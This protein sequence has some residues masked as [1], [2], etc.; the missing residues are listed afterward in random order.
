MGRGAGV[1]QPD[2]AATA[3]GHRSSGTTVVD[4]YLLELACSADPVVVAALRRKHFVELDLLG[5]EQRG[6]LVA[7]LREWILQWGHRPGIAEA[8]HVHPQTVSGRVNRL[9]DLLANELEDPVVRAELLVLLI[10]EAW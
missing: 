10:A 2:P 1:A 6:V 8:L 5:V 4:D 7:T 9:K 3:H